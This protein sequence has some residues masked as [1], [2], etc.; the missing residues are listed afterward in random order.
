ML[1]PYKETKAPEALPC[2]VVKEPLTKTEKQLKTNYYKL[3]K[4]FNYENFKKSIFS[5]CRPISLR[6]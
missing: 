2:E 5:V 6:L 1:R 3:L 4:T